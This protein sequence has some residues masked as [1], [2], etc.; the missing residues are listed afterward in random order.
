MERV[1][2]IKGK[3]E[4]DVF[5]VGRVYIDIQYF[6]DNLPGPNKAGEILEIHQGCGGCPGNVAV[7]AARLGLKTAVC[8]MVGSDEFGEMYIN[9]LKSENV[10][11]SCVSRDDVK[12]TGMSVIML[13]RRGTPA[14]VRRLG[15]NTELYFDDV[16]TDLVEKAK[17]LHMA[18]A[19]NISVPEETSAVAK[20]AGLVT[21]FDPGRS[22]SRL[23]YGKLKKIWDNTDVVIVNREEAGNIVGVTY[24]GSNFD[25]VS[26]KLIAAIGEDRLYVIKGGSEPVYGRS[27]EEE[28]FLRPFKVEVV[29]TLGAGDAFDAGVIAGLVWGKSL[30]ESIDYGNAVAALKIMKK[31]TQSVP[32]KEDMENFL[33]REDIGRV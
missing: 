22:M 3:A 32:Y 29:D 4:I 15:A 17:W 5:T 16:D 12:P 18:A 26:E 25:E 28:F 31:G 9:R 7:A 20:E 1:R 21:S 27:Q 30:R 8:A 2:R 11:A 19:S 24:D 14:I 6:V 23:G 33:K 13:D 10:D